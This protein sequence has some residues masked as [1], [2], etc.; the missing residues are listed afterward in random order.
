MPSVR[1]TNMLLFC[2]ALGI[3]TTAAAQTSPAPQQ[4]RLEILTRQGD[5]YW[6]VETAPDGSRKGG[7]V[8]VQVPLDRIDR[9]A[10][11]PIP[12]LP[13]LP[14]T[15]QGPP[16]ADS[17]NERLARIE[18]AL[19]SSQ[20]GGPDVSRQPVIS[21][22]S[23]P[24]RQ[25]ARPQA[26][27]AQ[28]RRGDFAV[29]YAFTRD[30]INLPL[31]ISASDAFRVASKFDVVLEGQFSHGSVGDVGLNMWGVMG[32]PRVSSGSRY[33]EGVSGFGQVLVGLIGVSA[34]YGFD[35]VSNTG[36]GIQPGFGVEVPLSP[37]V[38]IRPQFDL[39]VGRFGG[40]WAVDKRFNMNVVFVLFR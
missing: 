31:A 29:G 26:V 32:G 7:W 3:A 40:E 34:T 37:K 4:P 5:F 11:K 14:G 28:E 12:A 18:Q 39:P 19:A 27:A 2:V 16:D 8:N 1:L 33:G 6:V 22:Q 30:A 21:V 36:L 9:G 15:P 17:V 38:A 35:S 10:L 20:N 23:A 24:L 13:P 25:V